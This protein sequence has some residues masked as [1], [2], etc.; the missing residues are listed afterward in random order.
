MSLPQTVYCSI[1]NFLYRLTQPTVQ[2]CIFVKFRD[3]HNGSEMHGRLK[4]QCHEILDTFCI[5]K[6]PPGHNMK[7]QKQ[8]MC[9]RSRSR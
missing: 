9:P 6:T 5:K 1:S 2:Y 3:L 7:R 4:G 8:N